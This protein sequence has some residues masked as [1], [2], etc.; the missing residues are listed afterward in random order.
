VKT[1]IAL[2]HY[3]VYNKSK[4]VVTTCTA[5]FDLHDIARSAITFG[6]EKFFV[7][8]PLPA[9][10]AFAKRVLTY[11]GRG[12]GR[13]QNWTRSAALGLVVLKENLAEV[14]AAI[15]KKEKKAPLLVATSARAKNGVG[16]NEL[17]REAK[18]SKRPLLL[19]FGTGWGLSGEVTERCDYVLKAV[20]GKGAYN[21]LS[22]RSAAAII[23]D[24]LF[25]RN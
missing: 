2:L 18:K 17:L 21:H 25:G 11:W 8:N 13:S 24:R 4:K 22:V 23:L 15:K 6:V 12:E 14:I 19:I 10:Q 9:Q 7:V 5:T 20:S 1:Y 16:T 3:P